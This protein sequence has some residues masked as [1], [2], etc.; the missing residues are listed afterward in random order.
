[1]P[2][3][4]RAPVVALLTLLQHRFPGLDDPAPLIKEG[5]VLVN[6]VP[7]AAREHAYEPTPPSRTPSPPTARDDQAGPRPG[8]LRD[9]RCRHRRARPGRGS[10]RLHPGA[11]RCRGGPR[12]RRRRRRR[13]APRLAARRPPGDQPGT[14]QPGP[15][16]PVPH[17]RAGT[18]DHHGPVL[19]SH[20]R[21]HRPGRPADAGTSRTAHRTG[22]ANLRTPR[23][24][25]RRPAPAGRS[26]RRDRSTCP[27]RPRVADPGPAAITHP[28]S[29]R[30]GRNTPPR[31]IRIAGSAGTCHP[32][33]AG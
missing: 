21:G 17:Q 25:P 26:R 33:P 27:G 30:S 2:A 14:H 13:P 12:L 11:A 20:R 15:A 31:R 10:R 1:M 8:R 16:R 5:A 18:P 23:R 32:S 28:G 9:R 7:A 6:R 19:S 24:H 22:Q 3:A 4:G 29:K